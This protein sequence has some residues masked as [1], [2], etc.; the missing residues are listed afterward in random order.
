MCAV[1]KVLA[2][3]VAS[4]VQS[5][6]YTARSGLLATA[7]AHRLNGGSHRLS[8]GSQTQPN[9]GS[10]TQPRITSLTAAHR[11]DGASQA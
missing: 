7:A 6:V 2:K 4:V 5:D 10:Q 1:A 3:F 9:R 11:P 8:G